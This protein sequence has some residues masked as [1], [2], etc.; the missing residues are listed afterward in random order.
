MRRTVYPALLFVA[1]CLQATSFSPNSAPAV[2]QLELNPDFITVPAALSVT[3]EDDSTCTT[4]D[5]EELAG[6]LPPVIQSIAD[7]RREFQM[8]LGRA[9]DVVRKDY[10]EI[11]KSTPGKQKETQMDGDNLFVETSRGSEFLG[12]SLTSLQYLYDVFS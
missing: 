11:L 1:S 4:T 10:P 12:E 9:M 6:E 5:S 3:S 8:N 2:S 7:E